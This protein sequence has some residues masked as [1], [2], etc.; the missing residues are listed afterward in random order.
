MLLNLILNTDVK[1]VKS[2]C[3]N[4]MLEDACLE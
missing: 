1:A 3:Y 2:I 4:K